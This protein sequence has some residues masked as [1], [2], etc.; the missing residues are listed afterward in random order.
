MHFF[1]CVD[2]HSNGCYNKNTSIHT[3]A[4]TGQGRILK[5]GSY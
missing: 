4:L 3:N 1:K 5:Y 2:M